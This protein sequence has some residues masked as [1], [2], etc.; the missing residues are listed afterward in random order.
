MVNIHHKNNTLISDEETLRIAEF[1]HTH[2]GPFLTT[3][4]K[5][6]VTAIDLLKSDRDDDALSVVVKTIDRTPYTCLIDGIQI[7]SGCTFG[8]GKLR[9]EPADTIEALFQKDTQRI[10]ILLKQDILKE[11]ETNAE[12]AVDKHDPQMRV[13][14]MQIWAKSPDELFIMET[15]SQ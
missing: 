3:G 12:R 14:A 9:Y 15:E 11:I 4:L 7:T 6:G 1:F 2:I 13:K 5:I 10:K 8:N